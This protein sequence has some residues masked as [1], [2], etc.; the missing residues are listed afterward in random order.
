MS[1]LRKPTPAPKPRTTDAKNIAIFYAVFL[2][3]MVLAQLFTFDRFLEL[4]ISFE[5]PLGDR[6][7]YFLG[8]FIVTVEVFALPFLLRMPLSPAFRWFSIA[9]GWLAAL[10]W[11]K[12]SLWLV[13]TD[14]L[15]ENV[16]YLGTLVDLMPG[17]WAVFIS[18]ALVV[19]ALWSSW[20]MWPLKRKK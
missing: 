6:F 2:T 1:I 8:A 17:W 11:L 4:M 10:A 9:C 7:A 14:S 18:I 19:L 5:L 13:V 12:I 3:I 15:A 20:G 16:G